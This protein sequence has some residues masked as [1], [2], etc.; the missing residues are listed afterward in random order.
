MVMALRLLLASSIKLICVFFMFRYGP[1]PLSRSNQEFSDK[2]QLVCD[3]KFAPFAMAE[4]RR[5]K[6]QGQDEQELSHLLHETLEPVV[7]LELLPKLEVAVHVLVINAGGGNESEKKISAH[8]NSWLLGAPPFL[9][10]AN[11]ALLSLLHHWH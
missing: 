3:C 1:R 9:P 6:G 5:E 7:Q 10:Q 4:G 11:Y 2:G 8:A